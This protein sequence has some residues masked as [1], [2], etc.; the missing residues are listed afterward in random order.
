MY[1]GSIIENRYA[2]FLK[3][4]VRRPRTLGKFDC[5]RTLISR[6]DQ[7]RYSLLKPLYPGTR[8]VSRGKQ[9]DSPRVKPHTKGGRY[10]HNVGGMSVDNEK[11][12]R[13]L[14]LFTEIS[15]DRVVI[16]GVS[17][18]CYPSWFKELQSPCSHVNYWV[19]K[20]PMK[21]YCEKIFFTI[22]SCRIVWKTRIQIVW[23]ITLDKT[24]KT[25]QEFLI[26]RIHLTSISRQQI[27]K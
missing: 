21:R 23:L 2:T 4:R 8:P 22:L 24:N 27:P 6:S 3:D 19:K 10:Q 17:M 12:S 15:R 20:I 13:L 18:E 11:R 9:S 14:F 7:E 1:R 5:L 16:S 25:V 26:H